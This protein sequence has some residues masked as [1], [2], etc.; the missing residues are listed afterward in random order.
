MYCLRYC[1]ILLIT[2]VASSQDLHHQAF[3]SLS[4][5]V[6]TPKGFAISQTIGQQSIGGG[7]ITGSF[8][9][10]QQGFQQSL[11]Y[12]NFKTTTIKIETI[13]FPNPFKTTIN[14]QFSS[15]AYGDVEV[16]LF[17]DL[18]RKVYSEKGF[19]QFNRLKITPFENLPE[20]HYLVVLMSNNFN[21]SGHIIKSNL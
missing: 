11:M 5:S 14:F 6:V 21:F 3:S 16:F 12:N 13:M 7:N 9:L 19:I 8:Y 1:F 10:V 2:I 18:G 15:K 4:K 20:G 17:D